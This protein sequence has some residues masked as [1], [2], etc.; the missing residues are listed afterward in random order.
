VKG[1][2]NSGVSAA[3]SNEKSL[4]CR[5][6]MAV[7]EVRFELQLETV[8]PDVE[9]PVWFSLRDPHEEEKAWDRSGNCALEQ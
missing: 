6:V 2:P 9:R 4:A 7:E 5:S 8:S 1:T 3:R